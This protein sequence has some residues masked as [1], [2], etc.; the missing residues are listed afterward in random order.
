MIIMEVIQNAISKGK[1]SRSP[2][3]E[4]SFRTGTIN[5]SVAIYKKLPTGLSS[6]MKIHEYT[7]RSK[8]R[9]YSMLRTIFTVDTSK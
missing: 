1:F 3:S 9:T 6:P 5:G 4:R 2:N 8:K 7:A